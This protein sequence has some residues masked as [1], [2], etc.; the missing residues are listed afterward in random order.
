MF[1]PLIFFFF[2]TTPSG[3]Q[4]GADSAL[5]LN[6]QTPYKWPFTCTAACMSVQYHV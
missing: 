1:L 6:A 4:G 5:L 2:L 3:S